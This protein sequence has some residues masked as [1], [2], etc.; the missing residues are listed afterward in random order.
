M[1]ISVNGGSYLVVELHWEGSAPKAFFVFSFL[2]SF[3]AIAY[4]HICL[5]CQTLRMFCFLQKKI[6]LPVVPK[7]V[8]K[9]NKSDHPWAR[10]SFNHG[11]NGYCNLR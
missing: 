4:K 5:L 10:N 8:K 9:K 2:N 11:I 7:I 1:A 6:F 3:A